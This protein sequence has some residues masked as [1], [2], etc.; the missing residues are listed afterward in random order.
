M[1]AVIIKD[2]DGRPIYI[3]QEVEI[4]ELDFLKARKECIKNQEENTKVLNKRLVA[5]GEEIAK[6]IH[7]VNVL[8]GVE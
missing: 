1:K 4:G 5:L 6:L 3:A 2:L 8:K 7:E